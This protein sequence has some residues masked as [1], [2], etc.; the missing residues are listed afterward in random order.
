[1]SCNIFISKFRDLGTIVL[2]NKLDKRKKEV[3]LLDIIGIQKEFMITLKEVLVAILTPVENLAFIWS[4]LLFA[5]T[6]RYL[7][8]ILLE[9][10]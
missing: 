3:L 9:Q 5:F 4:N 8:N 6:C 1:M 10:K 7:N 2:L